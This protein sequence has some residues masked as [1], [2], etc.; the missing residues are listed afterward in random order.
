M[1]V[2]DANNNIIIGNRACGMYKEEQFYYR[3]AHNTFMLNQFLATP[4]KTMKGGK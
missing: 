3:I 4:T 1:Y 2:I